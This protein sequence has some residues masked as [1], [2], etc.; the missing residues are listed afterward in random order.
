MIKPLSSELAGTYS[1]VVYGFVNVFATAAG[2][3]APTVLGA[4][5]KG[6]NQGDPESWNM[7]F[8]IAGKSYIER[9][10]RTHLFLI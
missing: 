9:Y 6:K 1:L 8:I 10:I 7:I 4:V 2:L 5:L 3:L